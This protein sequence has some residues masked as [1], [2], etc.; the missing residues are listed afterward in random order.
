MMHIRRAVGRLLPFWL[1]L[2]AVALLGSQGAG[3]HFH[4][5]SHAN[6]RGAGDPAGPMGA[7]HSH[8]KG[9]HSSLDD[10]HGDHHTAA[11][12]DYDDAQDGVLKYASL[13]VVVL[14]LLAVLSIFAV[15]RL[16]LRP[17]RPDNFALP[18]VQSS[19]SPPPRAPP[20]L[21]RS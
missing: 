2:L 12:L 9:L 6:N 3:L 5:F 15:V 10:S 19:L 14:A 11:V 18:V 21:S 8:A 16:S 1:F 4:D 17:R 7:D 20:A 13:R